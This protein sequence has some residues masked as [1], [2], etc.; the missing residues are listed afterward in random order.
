MVIFFFSLSL[1]RVFRQNQNFLKELINE[2]V[3]N[4]INK[5]ID[6]YK[7][8]GYGLWGVVLRQTDE[9]IGDCGVTIQNIDGELLPEI[10]FHISPDYCLHGYATEAAMEIL[11]YCRKNFDYTGNCAS[12]K[13]SFIECID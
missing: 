7:I 10:G 6:R 12:D 9:L 4:W 3:E 13:S 8:Y 2:I 5:N 11:K 1:S